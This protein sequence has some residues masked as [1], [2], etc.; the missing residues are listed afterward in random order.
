MKWLIK[1]T[2]YA[3]LLLLLLFIFTYIG[4][5]TRWGASY[6][7][8]FLSKFTS[9]DIDVGIMGHEFSNPGEFIFQD[10]KLTAKNSDLSLD[11]R[12]VVVDVNWLN[13]FSGTAIKRLVIT[14][15]HYLQ[16]SHQIRCCSLFPRL[17]CNLK[18]ARLRLKRQ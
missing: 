14:K 9:Y 5:Q 13:L 16:Q 10:V 18:I 15:G 6:S 11:S 3:L 2:T 12:Q 4:L 8:Q 1:F 17:F 7:S